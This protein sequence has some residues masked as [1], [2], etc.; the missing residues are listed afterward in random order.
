MHNHPYTHNTSHLYTHHY[1][2]TPPTH[3]HTYTPTLPR[4][5]HTPLLRPKFS[6][7]SF[8]SCSSLCCLARRTH[9]L[10]LNLC[11]TLSFCS[12][13]LSTA[14]SAYWGSL[15]G[16]SATVLSPTFCW[17][18]KMMKLGKSDICPS[19]INQYQLEIIFYQHIC[20]IWLVHG[21][22]LVYHIPKL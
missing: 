13:I 15:E 20:W 3:T 12:L 7:L 5:H 16:S 14:G 8:L 2:D 19:L 9:C 18:E 21:H 1:T 6:K 17:Q 10:C 4:T 22:L 11:N